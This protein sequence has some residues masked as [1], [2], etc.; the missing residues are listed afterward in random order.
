MKKTYIQ[1]HKH[2]YTYISIYI[3]ACMIYKYIYIYCSRNYRSVYIFLALCQN[4]QS[5]VG[6]P[7]VT[8]KA[9]ALKSC[10]FTIGGLSSQSPVGEVSIPSSQSQVG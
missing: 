1:Q 2:V 8:V 6:F 5:P 9:S 3:F 10:R 4:P 7:S